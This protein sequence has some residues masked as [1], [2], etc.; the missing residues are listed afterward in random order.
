VRRRQRGVECPVD[1]LYDEANIRHWCADAAGKGSALADRALRGY[2]GWHLRRL[3]AGSHDASDAQVRPVVA[4]CAG[5]D[6]V[7]ATLAALA[8]A[9]YPL[10]GVPCDFRLD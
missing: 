4:P 2:L 5:D 10:A 8:R 1:L 9:E 3:F 7:S 6:A